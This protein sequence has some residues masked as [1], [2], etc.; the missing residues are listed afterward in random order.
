MHVSLRIVYS[1]LP[2][3]TQILP[4]TTSKSIILISQI[5]AAFIAG[6]MVMIPSTSF[7]TDLPT[8]TIEKR[9]KFSIGA[10]IQNSADLEKRAKFSIGAG[11][12]KSH[13]LEKRA[14]FS[15]GAGIQNSADLEKR[16]KF[17]IGAGIQ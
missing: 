11:I 3:L 10:G 2:H 12:Q 16:A 1:Q 9:A 4:V 17:S 15:I 8:T 6:A 13:V 14:K 7:A 5:A